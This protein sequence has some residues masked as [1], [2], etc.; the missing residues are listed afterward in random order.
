MMSKMPK[1]SVIVPVYNVEKVICKCVDSV[2]SQTFE[3]FELL[4]IDDGSSD[5]SGAICDAYATQ[6]NRIRVFHKKNGGV[7]SARNYGLSRGRGDYLVFLDSD[8]WIDKDFFATISRYFNQ[9]DMIFFGAEQMTSSGSLLKRLLPEEKNTEKDSLADLIYS[10]FIIGLLGYMWSFSIKRILIEGQVFFNEAISIHEDSLFCYDCLERIHSAISLNISP[11]HY[12]VY[13]K[14]RKTLSN[15][16]PDNYFSIAQERI[17]KMEKL[18]AH[19]AMSSKQRFYIINSLKYWAY[20]TCI[21]WAYQQSDRVEA[22]RNCLKSLS[23]IE[24]FNDKLS[25]RSRLFKWVIKMKNP[26]LMLLYKKI[27]NVLK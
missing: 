16:I 21:D 27:G 12:I 3:D 20:S 14:D 2:L 8:D 23:A 11:Y 26:Y 25:Y 24:D 4:L 17:N 7:S 18:Q 13:T 1:I 19:L 6:D 10:L 22:I 9:F 5:R 15:T